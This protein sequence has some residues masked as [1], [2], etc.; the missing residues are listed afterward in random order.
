MGRVSHE[1]NCRCLDCG[2]QFLDKLVPA[3]FCQTH[4]VRNCLECQPTVPEPPAEYRITD[5]LTATHVRPARP[6]AEPVEPTVDTDMGMA[7]WIA[8][9]HDAQKEQP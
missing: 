4:G 3:P 5:A 9:Q 1:A 7:G 8:Q 2:G 6:R